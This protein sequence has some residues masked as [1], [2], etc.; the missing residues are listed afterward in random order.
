MATRPSV[1]VGFGDAGLAPGAN[2]PLAS[3]ETPFWREDG[4]LLYF[5]STRG[6][7]MNRAI[8]RATWN[9]TNFGAPVPVAEL[10]TSFNETSPVVTPDDLTIYYATDAP[11]QT[12][13]DVWTATRASTRDP[14]G[15]ARPVAEVNSAASDGPTFVTR[16]GCALYISSD[17]RFGVSVMYVATRSPP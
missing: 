10:D 16:D 17:R 7:G 8:Y 15:S 1:E 12:Q 13:Y 2:D 11:S 3:D 4:L 6:P 14:F 5:G 9:G